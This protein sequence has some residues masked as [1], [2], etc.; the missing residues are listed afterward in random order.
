MLL[1]V[2]KI[3][4]SKHTEQERLE[5]T[6]VAL[7]L[8]KCTRKALYVHTLVNASSSSLSNCI[9]ACNISSKTCIANGGSFCS[10]TTA[11]EFF[12][13]WLLRIFV[14]DLFSA[15]SLV[16]KKLGIDWT[17]PWGE[18]DSPHNSTVMKRNQRDEEQ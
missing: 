13:F 14:A 2:S 10:T 5:H 6:F 16:H 12:L 7:V 17:V 1:P 11:P 4:K 15:A 18:E 3:H 8:E 9:G